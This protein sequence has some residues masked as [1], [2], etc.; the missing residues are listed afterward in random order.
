MP[1]SDHKQALPPGYQLGRYRLLE[2]LGV[3]GFGVTYL[4]EH[5]GLHHRVAVKEYLPNEF[6][7]REGATVH[8]KSPADREDFEWGLARFV[9]EARTLT[10]FRHPNLVRVSDYFEANN[11]AY[12]VMDYED[13][14]PLDALLERHGTLTEAQLRRVVLPVAD[15][16]RQVHAAGFLHRDIKPSNIFV[17]RSD[18]TPVLLDFGS[19]RQA[20]GR[21]SRSMTAIASAGYSPP[22]QYES[23][24][25]QGAW[26]DIYALSALCH[27]A[28][29]GKIPMEAPRRQGQ[30]LRSRVDPLPRLAETAP[31]G[32]SRAF[33][34]AVDWGL[35]VIETERPQSLDEW[36]ARMESVE[37]GNPPK[38]PKTPARPKRKKAVGSTPPKPAVG[39]AGGR[40]GGTTPS[41]TSAR[42]GAR[43]R[44]GFGTGAAWLVGAAA[45]IGVALY[46]AL[47]YWPQ[48]SGQDR[49]TTLESATPAAQPREVDPA[50]GSDAKT[51]PPSSGAKSAPRRSDGN[52]LGGGSALLVV[53]TTPA[54]VEVLIG[55]ESVGETPLELANLR[56]G[57]HDLTLRHTHYETVHLQGQRFTD[58]EVLRI[59]RTLRRGIGKLTVLT[60]PRNAWVE[61]DGERLASRTPVTLEGLP[62]G[63]LELTLGADG[64]QAAQVRAEVPRDGIGRLERTLAPIVYGT[65]T[66]ELVPA[67]AAVTLPD[68]EPPYRPGMRLPEGRHRVVARR[69]G[70]ADATREVAV[71]GNGEARERVELTPIPQPFTVAV[72]PS[73]ADVEVLGVAEAYRAGMPLVPGDYRVRVSAPRYEAQEELVR[74][75]MGPTRHAVALAKVRQPFTVEASPATAQVRLTDHSESY[76][77]G[78]P[79]PW[80]EYRVTVSAEGYVSKTEMMR[81]D[82][83]GP[84]V[85]R[86]ELESFKAGG[87]FRDCPECPEMIVVP[88]GSFLMG[89]PSDEEGRD[90]NE[91]PVHPVRIGEPFA[92]GVYEVTFAE[93][94]ACVADGGCGGHRPDDKGWGRGRRPVIR[95]SWQDAES[96]VSWLSRRTGERYRLPSESEWEYVARAGTTGPFHT[97][98]TISTDQANY[99]GYLVYGSG[100]K[101]VYRERTV[102]VGS[103]GANEFGLHDVHG[104]VREWVQDCW[105]DSYAGAPGDGSAW[106]SGNCSRRVLRGGSWYDSPRFLR[107][108][109]R[110]WFNAGIRYNLG[111]RVA[112]TLAP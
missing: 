86:V 28:V 99:N 107:S 10:R 31:A 7:V 84:T 12:I 82:P 110:H 8:P 55:D 4:G 22:E 64:H 23:Q 92:V 51:E 103:F 61:R 109:D 76:R 47:A 97:G 71:P 33:L 38:V 13:G 74:H 83:S 96:Y 6:A 104:N 49:G 87:R 32:Y 81:H 112:R 78:I 34:E 40:T 27:R 95:V 68:V 48:G 42:P 35:R 70:Y 73:D 21:K 58:G 26:T 85:H 14:E 88:S 1:E 15:G 100:R 93:W 29:V 98:S 89:S 46:F 94:E 20:L 62:A 66:L 17:R 111:F 106:E 102:P 72:T 80:G 91:G 54:G 105:N 75:G 65:L 77:A 19:A 43:G 24:G 45:A 39:S 101:G 3:G 11:T 41:G 108:A 5:V 36:L 90:G 59:E 16:L 69:E 37:A 50:G 30:L 18:E 52:L 25:A 60:T 9:D 79:L 57:A 44:E 2:V 53:E 56:A 63:L 67:D